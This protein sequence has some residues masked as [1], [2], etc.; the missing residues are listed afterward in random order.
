MVGSGHSS[1]LVPARLLCGVGRALST[2]LVHLRL[3]CSSRATQDIVQ[4]R[5]SMLSG[6]SRPMG[7]HQN[8]TCLLHYKQV[9]M[10]LQNLCPPALPSLD[11]IPEGSSLSGN[12]TPLT[13]VLDAFQ[14][15]VFV[16][17]LRVSGLVCK[18]LKS[19]ISIPYSSMILLVLILTEFKRC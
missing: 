16:L 9:R 12:W 13:Y 17:G 7:G 2:C 1:E 18:P 8:G 6:A 10:R 19:W 5:E 3:I 11:K 14:F 15:I 4:D